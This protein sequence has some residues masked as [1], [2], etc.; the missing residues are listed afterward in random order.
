MNPSDP[1]QNWQR[2]FP[3]IE[4][5][6]PQSPKE[7]LPFSP[8]SVQWSRL[9]QQVRDWFEQ[10]PGAG[11]AIALLAAVAIGLSLLKTLLQLVSAAIAT[12]FFGVLLYAAYKFFIAPSSSQ[13]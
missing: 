3:D 12:V 9:R 1:Q 6:E 7:E 10:L 2:K 8:S 4:V 13:S 11:K 5:E